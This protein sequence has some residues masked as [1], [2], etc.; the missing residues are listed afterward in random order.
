LNKSLK[1]ELPRQEIAAP[2]GPETHLSRKRVPVAKSTILSSGPINGG[3]THTVELIQPD[4]MPVA[5]TILGPAELVG[6]PEQR[7]SPPPAT[8]KYPGRP[9]VCSVKPPHLWPGSGGADGSSQ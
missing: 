3:D 1:R 5:V 7:I 8:S 9:C 6:P 2:D 4:R